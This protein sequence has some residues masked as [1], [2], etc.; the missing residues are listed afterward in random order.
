MI[1]T[2]LF[3]LLFFF[4]IIAVAN[5]PYIDYQITS[6]DMPQDICLDFAEESIK[7]QNFTQSGSTG[8]SEVVAYKGNYKAVIACIDE[9]KDNYSEITLF[10]VSGSSYKRASDYSNQ[11]KSSWDSM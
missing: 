7:E 9:N 1:K 8:S 3:I 2:S 11:L 5:P 6:A 4:T 10:I